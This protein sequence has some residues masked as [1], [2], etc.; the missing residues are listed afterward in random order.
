MRGR[1]WIIPIVL[2]AIVAVLVLLVPNQPSNSPD[3]RSD[4]DAADGT[5]ALF[6]LASRLGH[7]TSR[8]QESFGVPDT[9][10]IMFVLSPADPYEGG[11]AR[12]LAQWV[13]DGGTLVYADSALDSNLASQFDV[14]SS[15]EFLDTSSS[16]DATQAES[17]IDAG[18][19]VFDGVTSL[20][21][22]ATVVGALEPKTNQVPFM[23]VQVPGRRGGNKALGVVMA[24]GKGR[25]ILMG[26]PLV[27][28]NG[29]LGKADNGRFAADIL[30]MAP[31]SA[32]VRFDEFHHGGGGVSQSFNDWVTT[33]WGAA[34][35]WVLVVVFVGFLLRGRS[36][37]PAIP[38]LSTRDRS[39]AEYAAAVGTLLRRARARDLTLKVVADATRRALAERTG[40]GRGV[41]PDRL[42]AVLEQRSPALA[43]ELSQAEALSAGVSRSE[44]QLLRAARKLHALA[45]PS[46]KDR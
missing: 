24:L 8:V 43:A 1:G 23:R 4:S 9:P 5:S 27:F 34:L 31:A 16:S 20:R 44:A 21:T 33:P 39:S 22:S 18:T 42:G 29:V 26:D 37:G 40:L 32:P 45:Y 28:T 46:A 12:Q 38:I 36:F 15:E 14:S 2:G 6:E 11:Q 13:R 7:P 35:A 3:H 41:A 17:T 10:G 30:A 19:P 25:A